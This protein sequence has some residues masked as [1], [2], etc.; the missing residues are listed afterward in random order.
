MCIY[1]DPYIGQL[2]P[3]SWNTSLDE[4]LKRAV[5][6]D[7]MITHS[8]RLQK[9]REFLEINLT[10]SCGLNCAVLQSRRLVRHELPL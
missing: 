9:Y 4:E 2:Q 6:I 1:M 5:I 7:I 3:L 10:S 8:T